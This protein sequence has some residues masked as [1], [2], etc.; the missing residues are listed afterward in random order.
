MEDLITVLV[1][2]DETI[3]DI[4]SKGCELLEYSKDEVLGKNW[5]DSFIPELNREAER[6]S[7]HQIIKGTLRKGHAETEIVTKSGNELV[8]AWHI[9]L[10]K[11]KGAVKA[12]LFTGKEVTERKKAH[13][14]YIVLASFPAFNPNPIIELDF[15]GNITYTNPATKKV[16]PSFVKD[17]LN[18]PFFADWEKIV[19]R[20]T[21]KLSTEYAYVRE[22]KI[23]EHWYLQQF[24]YIPIG[25]KIR[26]YTVNIDEK[27][28]T[29]EALKV[30]EEKFR[31]LF[32]NMIDGYA[33]C[34]MLFNKVGRAEDFIY[35]EIN[36]AFEKVT[37][38][39]REKILGQK[40]SKI[41]P[42][43]ITENPELFEIYGRVAKTNKPERFEVFFKPLNIW[44]D[45]SVYSPQKGFFV[46]IFD[47]ITK[48]KELEQELQS[49][50][51]RLEQVVAQ[52]TAEYAQT[53]KRL[54]KEIM[55]HRKS[56]EG[57]LLRAMILD[58]LSQ[59]VVLTNLSGEFVYTNHAAC[60]LFGY[61]CEEFLDKNF[62]SLLKLT[63][64]EQKVLLE[65][66]QKTK[67]VELAAKSA[68]KDGAVLILQLR[69]SLIKTVH[70]KFV[71]SFINKT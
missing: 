68:K 44:F 24:S 2:A 59:A 38:L 21:G 26:V 1:N 49:Y 8:I 30:S 55:D 65:Q 67:E 10:V 60:N 29:E 4:N 69:L 19:P 53:N 64:E 13:D 28:K 66:V 71:I 40:V 12:V 39:K 15:D 3:E 46:A 35:L 61:T 43:T 16:F 56:E 11:S 25:P 54:S 48:R 45:I 63:F 34:K 23:G 42:E 36:D 32:E 47:D 58:N 18:Q 57:L 17:G 7:F 22:I 20:F 33:Y 70:G 37:G 27:K 41:F 62:L 52:R 5:F 14:R 50:N 9:L 51:D 6:V 31:S